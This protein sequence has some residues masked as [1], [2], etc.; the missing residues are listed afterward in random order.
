MNMMN[1]KDAKI[2]HDPLHAQGAAQSAAQGAAQIK[3]WDPLVRIFHWSLVM[4]FL[5]AWISADE[6]DRLHEW[7]GYAVMG[8]IAFRVVWGV[9]GTRYARFSNFV[10][11]RDTVIRYL[12]DVFLFRAK[13]YL[14]HN[15]A[16]GLMVIVLLV[17]LSF[18][19]ATG[20]MTTTVVFHDLEW[21]EDIHEAVANLTLTFVG[22]HIVGVLL[23]SLLHGENLVRSMFNGRKRAE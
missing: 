23:T 16:G 10:C 14:G 22:F 1:P 2:G 21:V 11:R 17:M 5:V 6:W 13:R 8:L 9:I 3:V 18:L 20:Y 19:F 15:P 7:A 4:S 12:K